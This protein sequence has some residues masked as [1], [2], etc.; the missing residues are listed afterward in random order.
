V[1]DEGRFLLLSEFEAA[2]AYRVSEINLLRVPGLLAQVEM[3]RGS[4]AARFGMI[5]K[6][7]LEELGRFFAVESNHGTLDLVYFAVCGS[8]ACTCGECFE[9]ASLHRH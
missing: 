9:M 4:S 1:V 5:L 6:F 7:P 8:V 2:Q 3:R